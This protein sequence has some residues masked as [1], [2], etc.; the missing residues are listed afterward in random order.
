MV[1]TIRNDDQRL[2]LF[3]R[4]T[5]Q[6]FY[7]VMHWFSETETR[8]AAADFRLM[9]RKAVDSLVRLRES[10]RFLRGMVQWL[11]FSTAKVP[12][13]PSKRVAGVSKYNLRRMLIFASDAIFSFSLLPLRLAGFLGAVFFLGGL[14]LALVEVARALAGATGSGEGTLVVLAAL[15]VVGGT[16]MGSLGI[17]GEYV[18]R[19][20]EQVKGRPIYLLKETERDLMQPALAGRGSAAA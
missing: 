4:L 14:G 2:S 19:I 5:S 18:G 7:R 16:I 9:T 6:W 8:P 11:G 12:Y 20:Y 10:H 15:G 13:Q 3:K 17:L 1:L